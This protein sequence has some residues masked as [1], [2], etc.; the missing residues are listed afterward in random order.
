MH[1]ALPERKTDDEYTY[2]TDDREQRADCYREPREGREYDDDAKGDES[3]G[4]G[5][6]ESISRLDDDDKLPSHRVG[7]LGKVCLSFG[8]GASDEL[9]VN[10]GE[11]ASKGYPCSRQRL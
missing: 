7:V 8:D 5:H 3:T 4:A 11:L 6:K 2:A 9:F 1:F 10:L